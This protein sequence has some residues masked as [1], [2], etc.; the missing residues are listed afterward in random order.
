M[1]VTWRTREELFRRRMDRQYR[2]AGWIR[3][4]GVKDPQKI[5]PRPV[6]FYADWSR[7]PWVLWFNPNVI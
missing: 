5:E 3:V 4:E 1:K 7:R 2:D 6:E